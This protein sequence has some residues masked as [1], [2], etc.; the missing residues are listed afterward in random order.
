MSINLISASI[1]VAGLVTCF[2]MKLQV[3]IH[4]VDV[5]EDVLHYPGDDTHTV[6]VVEIPLRIQHKLTAEKKMGKFI[7]TLVSLTR[8]SMV[9]VFPEDVW[10][11]AKIVPLYPS[12]TSTKQHKASFLELLFC[13][14]YYLWLTFHNP[15]GAGIIHL[16]LTRA[17]L[18]DSVEHVRFAL[19][20]NAQ[21]IC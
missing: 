1:Q 3:F 7:Y 21:G 11:Y 4:G 2:D 17:G 14:F 13:L 18:K 9:W 16:L 8:T 15:L 12:R 20:D 5:V 19:E 6:C 10:P